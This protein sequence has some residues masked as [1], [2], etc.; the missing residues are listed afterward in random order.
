M[1]ILLLVLSKSNYFSSI[2]VLSLTFLVD[3][4]TIVLVRLLVL[5]K[6]L[7]LSF[8]TSIFLIL[9]LNLLGKSVKSRLIFLTFLSALQTSVLVLRF[10]FINLLIL[11]LIYFIHPLIPSI[12]SIPFPSL[13][14]TFTSSLQQRR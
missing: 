6:C 13:N 12:L 3:R 9:L 8:L 14:F 1:P 2:T 4:L 5:D 7:N 10:F 11:T